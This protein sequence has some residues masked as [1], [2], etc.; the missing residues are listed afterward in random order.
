MDSFI[1]FRGGRL[2]D[3]ASSSIPVQNRFSTATSDLPLLSQVPSASQLPRPSYQIP[4]PTTGVPIAAYME[5]CRAHLKLVRQCHESERTMWEMEA[6][7]L[8][9]RIA[10]LEQ[11][12]PRKSTA[13]RRLSNELSSANFNSFGSNVPSVMAN[14]IPRGRMHSEPTI[15]GQPVWR[16]PETTPPVTRVFTHDDDVKHLPSI[17]EDGVSPTSGAQENA[18]I[19][20]EQVDKSLD[21]ITLKKS[22]LTSSFDKGIISPQ[23]ASPSRSPP[24]LPKEDKP[25][26]LDPGNL[27][28]PL[29]EKLKLHAGHTPR[30]YDGALSSDGTSTADTPKQEKP[31]A[32]APTKRSSSRP[33]ENSDS[34][35]GSN[36]ALASAVE[37]MRKE[38]QQEESEPVFEAQDDPALKGPLMLDSTANTVESASFLTELDAKLI[39]EKEHQERTESKLSG[40][41]EEKSTS[42]DQQGAQ[43]DASQD[44]EMPRLKMKRSTNFGSAWG[45]NIPGRMG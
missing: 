29:D 32:P 5:Q 9:A 4:N 1:D 18:P 27:L 26:K 24:P 23:F 15:S 25:L 36:L 2:S 33:S 13:K 30:A 39:E 21:G 40:S 10:E 22:A 14:G 8:R 6:K 31:Y 19:P 7:E 3:P 20:V 16:G 17:S 44:D 42:S 28:A 41:S 11:G 37:G 12:F 35:F 43:S 34:Y 38:N 45:G